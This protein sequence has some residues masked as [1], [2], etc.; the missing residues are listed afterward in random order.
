MRV[1]NVLFKIIS[2]VFTI[3]VLSGCAATITSLPKQKISVNP[4][5]YDKIFLSVNATQDMQTKEGYSLALPQLQQS[6]TTKLLDQKITRN[7][8][9]TLT[10][11]QSKNT[12][13]L[14][15]TILD[16]NHVSGGS[17]VLLGV[18]GGN[19]RLTTDVVL[20]DM[21]QNTV[22]GEF[23]VTSQTSSS[24]GIFRG[25]TTSV[26]DAVSSQ[27]ANNLTLTS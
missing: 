4:K 20:I 6:L 3:A 24:G 25:D 16:F 22:V 26:I 9:T 13:K 12:L 5:S 21:N 14:K 8:V 7:V 23:T 15:L 19:A 11:D 17:S 1:N 18:L 10:T 2:F 27:I